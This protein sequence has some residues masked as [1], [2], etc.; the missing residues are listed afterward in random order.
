MFTITAVRMWRRPFCPD[1]HIYSLSLKPLIDPLLLLRE[2]ERP[3]CP[4]SA[5]YCPRFGLF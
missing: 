2:R 4:T 1:S 3:S 5:A